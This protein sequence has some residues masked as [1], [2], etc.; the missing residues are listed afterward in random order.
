M[1]RKNIVECLY[2]YTHM[3]LFFPVLFVL[4]S[5]PCQSQ[6]ILMQSFKNKNL[7][8]SI[9]L[10]GSYSSNLEGRLFYSKSQVYSSYRDMHQAIKGFLSKTKWSQVLN[11]TKALADLRKNSSIKIN[12]FGK[13]PTAAYGADSKK[14]RFV[15]H[16]CDITQTKIYTS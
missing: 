16:N 8:S 15:I 7:T 13:M 12:C 1:A 9:N 5:L 3:K 2:P 14:C 4:T 6:K 10:S 11:F